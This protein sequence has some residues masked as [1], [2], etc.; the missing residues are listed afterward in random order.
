M[1]KEMS[2]K[3]KSS[4]V[5]SDGQSEG[6]IVFKLFTDLEANDLERANKVILQFSEDSILFKI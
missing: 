2:K 4:D 3:S 1:K 5:Q 6:S